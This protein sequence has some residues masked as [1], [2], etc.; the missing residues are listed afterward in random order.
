MILKI[1]LIGI[2][3]LFGLVAP[4]IAQN[5][6]NPNRVN[7]THYQCYTVA[8]SNEPATIKA[9]R[10]Q[11]GVSEPV[12]LD[13]AVMLC[14]PTAKNGVAAKDRVTHYLCYEDE[15][16]KPVNRKA[17]VVN[18]FTKPAGIPLTIE[19]PKMLCVP[20]LKRLHPQ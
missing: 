7:P 13:K 6:K 10:D 3:I 1:N 8:A 12:K 19:A 16:V 17:V 15:G 4:A 11:F 14:A 18:Q 5:G 9:L 2:A 20:S